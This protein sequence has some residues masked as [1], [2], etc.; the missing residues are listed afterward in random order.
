M[1]L[2]GK[3]QLEALEGESYTAGCHSPT[4]C[5]VYLAERDI[6]GIAVALFPSS[7]S[8]SFLPLLYL[9]IT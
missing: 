1:V 4:G 6:K 7:L 2:N 3:G 8:G 5:P 9:C